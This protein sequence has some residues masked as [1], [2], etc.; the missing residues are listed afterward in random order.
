MSLPLFYLEDLEAAGS[1]QVLPED[2]SRH[3]IQVLRMKKG[4]SLRLT[5]GLGKVAEAVITDD[6]K[7]HCT[8]SIASIDISEKPVRQNTIAISLLKNVT[9]FEWFLEK[10]AELGIARIVPLV[11]NR[12]EKI[13]FRS[14]RMKTILVSAMLQSQQSW[15]TELSEPVKFDRFIDAGEGKSI[16][17]FIAHCEPGEKMG[18]SE[19][20]RLSQQSSTVLIGP[21]G[22]FTLAEIT[23]ASGN[24]FRAVTLGDTRLRT[25]TAGIV[26]ATLL[27]TIGIL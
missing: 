25:E 15:L 7:K 21:E 26:A 13:H 14:E 27:Q 20:L 11:C 1:L 9:R 8:V 4:E 2:S 5:N 19:A 22:D 3:I 17:G 23:R 6:H 18:L 24:G 12:T 10:S 16:N